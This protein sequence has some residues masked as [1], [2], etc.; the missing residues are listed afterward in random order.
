[1]KYNL[2]R[3]CVFALSIILSLSVFNA[4][5]LSKGNDSP[6]L[7]QN[8]A[9]GLVADSNDGSGKKSPQTE[10]NSMDAAV[11]FLPVLS[12][13]VVFVVKSTKKNPE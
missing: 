13:A 6:E 11:L 8:I 3:I 7:N 1:M 10:D 12:M 5:A 9:P 4:Y 2:K